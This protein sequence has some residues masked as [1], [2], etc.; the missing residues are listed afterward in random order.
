MVPRSVV[1]VSEGKVVRPLQ[2]IASVG[3]TRCFGLE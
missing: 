2:L 3:P 1:I